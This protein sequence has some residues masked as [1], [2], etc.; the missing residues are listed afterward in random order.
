MSPQDLP[1]VLIGGFAY[2]IKCNPDSDR[3]LF[4]SNLV[5]QH[6]MTRM[7]LQLRTDLHDQIRGEALTHEIIHAIVTTYLSGMHLDEHQ[8]EAMAQGVF[9][10]LRDNFEVV[11]YIQTVDDTSCCE[12]QIVAMC[13]DCA[14]DS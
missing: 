4:E 2:D 10:F 9:Q 5:A 11:E 6:D 1:S 8:V 14:P 7:E 12:G 3:E 13:A